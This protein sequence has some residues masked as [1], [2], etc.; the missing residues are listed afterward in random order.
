[1]PVAFAALASRERMECRMGTCKCR[2]HPPS[3]LTEPLA[4]VSA[5]AREGLK[6]ATTSTGQETRHMQEQC[7]HKPGMARCGC[8]GM[9]CL[10][11]GE[12]GMYPCKGTGSAQGGRLLAIHGHQAFMASG[13]DQRRDVVGGR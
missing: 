5:L 12:C 8:K 13:P 1:M 2:T 7:M 6:G 9:V 11:D 4:G 10:C 3:S